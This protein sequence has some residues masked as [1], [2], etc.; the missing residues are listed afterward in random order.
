MN[1]SETKKMLIHSLN[2]MRE[3]KTLAISN[4]ASEDVIKSA[5]TIIDYLKKEIEKIDK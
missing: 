3:S 1:D 4:N 2:G 5:D